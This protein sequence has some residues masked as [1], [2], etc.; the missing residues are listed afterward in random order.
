MRG[1]TL[2]EVIIAGGLSLLLAGLFLPIFSIA[3]RT[4]E[5]GQASQAAQRDTLAV[6]YRLRRDY[7]SAKP[8]SLHLRTQSGILTLSFIS[9]DSAVG[10]EAM[11][12]P[13]GEILW[14]K[15]VQ[16]RYN[17]AQRSVHRREEAIDPPTRNPASTPPNWLARDAHRLASH[18][19]LFD[20]Q[21][22]NQ[23]VRL[24]LRLRS[25]EEQAVS[26]MQ[27]YLLPSLYA[28]DT[29]GQ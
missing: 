9:Y 5:R 25:R 16:Y 26:S 17:S 22:V 2:I 24:S 8:E 6:T 12:T 20:I 11:W 15:W 18:I 13:K 23:D 14:R 29:A 27:V 28:L 3:W 1:V 21:S 19:E 4:W 7:S 10:T